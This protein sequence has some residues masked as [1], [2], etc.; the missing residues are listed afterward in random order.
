MAKV[1]R[2]VI[3]K[4][5]KDVAN[6]IWNNKVVRY[7]II[8]AAIWYTAGVASSYFSA[9]QPT[10]GASMA[11]GGTAMWQTATTG[12]FVSGANV[13]NTA[14]QTTAAIQA[15]AAAGQASA[16]AGGVGEGTGVAMASGE[17]VGN[18]AVSEAALD[19]AITA[20]TTTGTAAPSVFNAGLINTAAPAAASTGMTTAQLA[21]TM[22][23][24][25]AVMGAMSSK[26]AQ[27]EREYQEGIRQSRGTYGFNYEG[28]PS[29]I[30]NGG[31]SPDSPAIQSVQGQGQQNVVAGGNKVRP[32]RRQDLA[33]LSSHGLINRGRRT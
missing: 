23:G 28:K 13:A 30:I 29:G 27:R 21:A 16:I 24:G 31:M 2:K 6:K 17:A 14:T 19:A 5:I 18:V 1:F 26:D 9:A 11:N 12:Q 22:I 15:G 25:Q 3:P 33:K 32:V 7:V 4:P 20:G 10:L 8:A